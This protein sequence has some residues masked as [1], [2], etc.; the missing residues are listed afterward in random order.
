SGLHLGIVATLAD[1]KIVGHIAISRDHLNDPVGTSGFLVVDPE[2]RGHGIGD[3][4]SDRK[5]ER[6][7]RAGLRGMLGMAVTVHTASQ[8]TSLRE[9]GCEVGVLLAAQEDRIVMRG[10]ATDAPRE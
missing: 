6:A 3:V 5:R 2:F 10:I 4:L 8:K 1:G 9:G 7:R